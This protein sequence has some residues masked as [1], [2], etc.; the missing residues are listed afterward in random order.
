MLVSTPERTTAPLP[1]ITPLARSFVLPPLSA[2]LAE[3]TPYKT[4]LPL[5]S[6]FPT[7]QTPR[8]V[9]PRSTPHLSVKTKSP[10]ANT[11]LDSDADTSTDAGVRK[12]KASAVSPTRDFAFISH[13]PATYPSQEPSIDNASLARRKRRRTSPNELAI[14]NQEFVAGATPNKLRRI[15]IAARV[16]MTEKAIQIWFQNKRQSLRRLRCSDKEV[17]E[18]PPTPDLSVADVTADV[19][20]PSDA[21]TS[22]VPLSSHSHSSHSHSSHSLSSHSVLS[23]PV[24]THTVLATPLKPQTKP[25]AT[26]VKPGLPKSHSAHFASPAMAQLSPIRSLS[27]PN[28]AQMSS[29]DSSLLSPMAADENRDSLVLNLTNK[30]QPEFARQCAVAATQ[31]M[32]FRLAPPKDRKP[33]APVDHNA[34]AKSS[35]ELQ[36]VQNLLSLRSATY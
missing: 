1:A 12:R 2:L 16:N 20:D 13:S 10:D 15:E 4:Q 19:T 25:L 11:S 24:S 26:P 6:S 23:G 7:P 34:R 3:S 32:T 18:L 31:V 28:V 8:Y 30:K 27:A 5:I 35:K 29:K 36:C 9:L 14:L 21:N 33:L 22:Y 17:T